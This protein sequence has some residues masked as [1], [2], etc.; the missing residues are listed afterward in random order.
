ME[1]KK[2]GRGRKKR[3]DLITDMEITNI[4]RHLKFLQKEYRGIRGKKGEIEQ[5]ERL[6]GYGISFWPVTNTF[7]S[8]PP[9]SNDLREFILGERGEVYT[10]MEKQLKKQFPKI[11]KGKIQGRV[12]TSYRPFIKKHNVNSLIGE[13]FITL[14]EYATG[15]YMKIDI[16]EPDPSRFDAKDQKREK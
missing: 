15:S 7:I 8:D 6:I 16:P 1:E 3:H 2:K 14:G 10:F 11:D 5:L 12:N 9:G 13:V 4:R